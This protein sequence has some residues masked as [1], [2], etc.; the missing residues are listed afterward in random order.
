MQPNDHESE[1][2]FWSKIAAA[3]AEYPGVLLLN[4][5]GDFYESYDQ[6]AEL[7]ARVLKCETSPRGQHKMTAFPHQM[8]RTNLE[9]L[10][11][12]GFRF[13]ICEEAA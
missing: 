13:A 8:L 9:K 2:R 11:R 10:T 12:A 7:L 3:R 5:C 4:R 1:N 6:D